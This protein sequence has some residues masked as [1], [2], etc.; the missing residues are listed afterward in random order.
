MSAE[1]TAVVIRSSK[2][3]SQIIVLI[4]K[5]VI[6]VSSSQVKKLNWFLLY[7]K[8]SFSVGLKRTWNTIHSSEVFSS[9]FQAT[10]I[11]AT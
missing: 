7:L 4:F 6:Q 10:C 1:K 5:V 2:L 9:Y 3:E 11:Q 8:Q